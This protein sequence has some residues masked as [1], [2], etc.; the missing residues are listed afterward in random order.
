MAEK[1]QKLRPSTG[2][3]HSEDFGEVVEGTLPGAGEGK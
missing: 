3:D 1:A 2:V